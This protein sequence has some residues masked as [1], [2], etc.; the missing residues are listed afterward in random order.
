MSFILTLLYVILCI[1][2]IWGGILIERGRNKNPVTSESKAS[3]PNAFGKS[4]SE[5]PQ[6]SSKFE[7]LQPPS[8][9][10]TLMDPP[11]YN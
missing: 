6:I 2:T 1:F 9:E 7:S 8:Y 11:P 5:L 3:S 10:T 4:T